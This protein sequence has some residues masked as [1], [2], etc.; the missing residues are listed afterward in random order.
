MRGRVAAP[1][2]LAL[3]FACSS[4]ESR[5]KPVLAQPPA[6]MPP[7][8][9]VTLASYGR[10]RV[11]VVAP[12][13][14]FAAVAPRDKSLPPLPR[15]KADEIRQGIKRLKASVEDL[16]HYLSQISGAD[17]PLVT[18]PL[19]LPVGLIPIYIAEQA[20]PGF[21]PVTLHAP[22]AQGFRVAVTPT[23]VGLFGESDLAA[24]YAIYELLDRLGCRWFMPGAL[25]EEIPAPSELGLPAADDALAPATLY[26]GLW[27]ANEDFQRRNRLGGL[28]L[29]AGH[30]LENLITAEERAL[31]PEW[32]AIVAGTP[33]ATRLRWSEPE[34]AT[35]IAQHLAEQLE[36]SGEST[37]SLSPG[38]GGGFDETAD[39]ALDANDWDPTVNAVSLT[40]RLLV[41]ANRVAKQLRPRY[42]DVM[43]GLLA[44][45][46]YTRPPVR[47]RVEPNVVPVIAPITYCRQHPWSDNACPGA[48]EARRLVEGWGARAD[49]L[50]YRGYAFNLSEPAAP[51]PMQRKWS[52]ELP[53]LLAHN[54]RF[55]QPETLP[56]FETSLPAL[57][58]GV[59][60]SWSLQQSPDVV[61]NE[62]YD[63]FYGHAAREVRAYVD[64]IDGAWTNTN[65][66][67]G[68]GLGYSQRFPIPMLAQARRLLDRA[69][70]TC[71]TD[72]ERA[73]VELLDAS[74]T[75]LELY[76]RSDRALREGRLDDVLSPYLAWQA[77]ASALAEQYAPN[78]AFGKTRWAGPPGVYGYYA[79]RFL[80]ATYREADRIAREG[81]LLTPSPLCS[82]RYRVA[83]DLDLPQHYAVP[84]LGGAA[85]ETNVCTQT[86][87]TIGQYD[88]FGAMWYDTVF[89]A[90]AAPSKSSSLWLSKVDGEVQVWLNDRPL[91]T[92][93]T[94]PDAAI[95]TETHLAPLTFDASNALLAGKNRLTVLVRRTRLAELG[96]SGLLGPV[97]VYADR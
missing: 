34:V 51:N 38:D 59:R 61:L 50:A 56:N 33:H 60:L 25:G 31:H 92:R 42:P 55:F 69:E 75:Q 35:A 67:S 78:S 22:G 32:R 41:L 46:S 68:G 73:R 30:N 63:R 89:E 10:A 19:Q 24:S 44:Y 8:I 54:V 95:S 26:R 45:S 16:V 74:L 70:A 53:F 1:V 79:K 12:P 91:R 40:D 28:K 64:A 43:L 9:R 80:E 94:Q 86:W 62:L 96:A 17:V 49:K 72:V 23:K 14:L 18:D 7:P 81:I 87:S 37:A 48:Q 47:E 39:R 6:A 66:F 58:L 11:A 15:A 20:L 27:Y 3:L 93:W 29:A 21:G 71:Q 52:Y 77:R 13:R 97:Y 83:K 2:A 57:W 76:M 82:M 90:K 65:E 85:A 84:E 4:H 88:Y 5:G 36:K